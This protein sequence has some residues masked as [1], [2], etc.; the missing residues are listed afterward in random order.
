MKANTGRWMLEQIPSKAHSLYLQSALQTGILSLLCLLIFWGSYAVSSVRSLKQKKD[1]SFFA[2]RT[3]SGRYRQG[4][5]EWRQDPWNEIYFLHQCPA[6]TSDPG[7]CRCSDAVYS[8]SKPYFTHIDHLTAEVWQ[9]DTSA[10][11]DP[12]AQ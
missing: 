9:D 10:G 2:G 11:C 8:K 6:V 5:S 12:T 1:S 3:Q 4:T 7:L